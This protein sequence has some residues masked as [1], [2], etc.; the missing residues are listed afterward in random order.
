MYTHI[1]I[2]IYICVC[3]RGSDERC[4]SSGSVEK[5]KLFFSSLYTHWQI[6]TKCR[7]FLFSLLDSIVLLSM[8]YTSQY[9]HMGAKESSSSSIQLGCIIFSL[10]LAGSFSVREEERKRERKRKYRRYL[11]VFSYTFVVI[12]MISFLIIE[13]G[14][15]CAFS[16]NIFLSFPR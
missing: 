16:R 11:L 9:I 14:C 3:V 12:L 13:I 5:D 8:L 7:H 2:Y 4:S 10:S 6:C 1:Y 15:L